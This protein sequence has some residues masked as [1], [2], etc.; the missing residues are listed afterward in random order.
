M[1]AASRGIAATTAIAGTAS[2]A[3]PTRA[4]WASAVPP[5]IAR[6]RHA[7]AAPASKTSAPTPRSRA[8]RVRVARRCVA[9]TRRGTQSAVMPESSSVR[10]MVAAAV[11][12]T[13]TVR[14]PRSAAREPALPG[15]PAAR[16]PT[17]KDAL[18]NCTV[19]FW[20]ETVSAA[21]AAT[22]PSARMR[23]ARP[24]AAAPPTPANT[25][26]SSATTGRA[27]PPSAAKTPTMS[28]F[29][30]RMG[31]WSAP[32]AGGAAAPAMRTARRTSFAA[33][34]PASPTPNAATTIPAPVRPQASAR[35]AHAQAPPASR[36]A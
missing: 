21:S 17:R 9:R 25:P 32:Q 2:C 4:W 16:V 27:A 10:P 5:P 13:R 15:R 33:T 34:E 22:R 29:A 12:K 24:K 23:P 6:T 11:S 31:P 18:A 14:R 35:S 28:R 1:A 20:A 36:E 3:A 30:A 7:S 26:R 8:S 19:A